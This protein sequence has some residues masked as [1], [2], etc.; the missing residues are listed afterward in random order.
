VGGKLSGVFSCWDKTVVMTFCHTQTRVADEL[1]AECDASSF[2]TVGVENSVE[3]L[4][5]LFDFR[6]WATSPVVSHVHDTLGIRTH[7]LTHNVS[8]AT[9]TSECM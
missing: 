6:F 4:Y 3:K 9:G 7:Q 5:S 8:T 2:A 1:F